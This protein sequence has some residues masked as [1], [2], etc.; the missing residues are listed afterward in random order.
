M[1]LGSLACTEEAATVIKAAFDLGSGKFRVLV[2]N[3]QGRN[4]QTKYNL[5]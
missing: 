5:T 4:I 1:S 3:V 2:A